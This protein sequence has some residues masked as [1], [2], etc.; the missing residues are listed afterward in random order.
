MA[1]PS[2]LDASRRDECYSADLTVEAPAE[3]LTSKPVPPFRY[4][5]PSRPNI[6]PHPLQR[7]VRL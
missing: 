7:L 4:C 6:R 2:K 1:T 3:T 5:R